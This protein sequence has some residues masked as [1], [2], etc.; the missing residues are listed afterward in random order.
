MLYYHFKSQ[1]VVFM[2]VAESSTDPKSCDCD[3]GVPLFDLYVLVCG[4]EMGGGM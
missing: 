3:S 2:R 1:Y 4:F